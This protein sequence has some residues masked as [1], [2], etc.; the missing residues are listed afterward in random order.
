M[1]RALKNELFH[2]H[3]GISEEDVHAGMCP[4]MKNTLIMH[5]NGAVKINWILTM[6]QDISQVSLE[7]LPIYYGATIFSAA[8]HKHVIFCPRSFNRISDQFH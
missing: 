4:H 1:S 5:S 2:H 8:L 7:S 6:A 3:G